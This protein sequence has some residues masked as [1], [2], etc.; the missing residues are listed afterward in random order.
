MNSIPNKLYSRRWNKVV[1]NL[2]HAQVFT[3]RKPKDDNDKNALDS[4]VIPE[5]TITSAVLDLKKPS[6]KKKSTKKT[7]IT[8][9]TTTTTVTKRVTR[10]SAKASADLSLDDVV[11]T[12]AI[13]AQNDER[14][15]NDVMEEVGKDTSESLQSF[16]ST[17]QG[18]GLLSF[19]I[20][21]LFHEL[22]IMS[23]CRKI[24]LENFAFF[25][26]QGLAVGLEVQLRQGHLKQEPQGTTRILCIAI[27]FLFMSVTGRLFTGPFLR[28]DFF[29]TD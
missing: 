17:V 27:Q 13:I 22:I 14:G 23:V 1:R 6:I 26:I 5:K 12:P 15:V 9:T 29:R 7:I 3:R 20:S 28:Y 24:T 21:G 8:T 10:S 25:T 2:L 19:I 11:D 4:S 16:W 18:R